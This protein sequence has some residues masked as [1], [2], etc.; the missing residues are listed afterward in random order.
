MFEFENKKPINPI[1]SFVFAVVLFIAFLF[2]YRLLL[3]TRYA[4]VVQAKAQLMSLVSDPAKSGETKW[5]S[6]GV[7]FC[8]RTELS[9]PEF[10][11]AQAL[12]GSS[13]WKPYHSQ[14][15]E[16]VVEV[17]AAGSIQL[18]TRIGGGMQ[19]SL[20]AADPSKAIA[21]ISLSGG[22]GDAQS[23]S[24][25]IMHFPSAAERLELNLAPSH[26]VYPFRGKAV[27]GKDVN[28]TGNRLLLSGKVSLFSGDE[29]AATGRREITKNELMLGDQL[30][31]KPVTAE[32]KVWYKKIL[33]AWSSPATEHGQKSENESDKHYPK[34]FIYYRDGADS[35]ELRA[36]GDP[37]GLSLTRYGDM[38]F[39][40][41]PGLFARLSNDPL[42]AWM[43]PFLLLLITLGNNL[44]GI[45]N[46]SPKFINLIRKRLFGRAK[47]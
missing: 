8:S 34:G 37:D 44:K 41:Q 40:L 35:F 23:S 29:S 4:Y 46:V 42:L 11:Q 3:P 26:G 17:V 31:L 28:W 18:S 32:D 5:R 12:C 10:P 27:F 30:T 25:L 47:R 39:D 43:T 16:Q 38:S 33:Q 22:R 15:L 45:G 13:R 24:Q 36:F 6:N 1:Q 2:V 20:R 9:L 7:I 21:R 19:M 14:D